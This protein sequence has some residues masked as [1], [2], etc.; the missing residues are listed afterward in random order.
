MRV[1]HRRL[2][3]HA[4]ARPVVLAAAAIAIATGVAATMILAVT[5]TGARDAQLPGWMS[6]SYQPL[7]WVSAAALLL[8]LLVFSVHRRVTGLSVLAALIFGIAAP[9][10]WANAVVAHNATDACTSDA[11]PQDDNLVNLTTAI[12]TITCR[13]HNA[14]GAVVTTTLGFLHPLRGFRQHQ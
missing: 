9:N 4:A 14:D 7:S 3:Q 1:V 5:T 2:T 10:L 13:W 11:S 8:L 12:N 6:A